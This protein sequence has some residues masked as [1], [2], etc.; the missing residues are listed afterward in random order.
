MSPLSIFGEAALARRN[1]QVLLQGP[2]IVCLT[3]AYVTDNQRVD[4]QKRATHSSPRAGWSPA[5]EVAEIATELFC[6]GIELQK[7]VLVDIGI[8]NS[9]PFGGGSGDRVGFVRRIGPRIE[10][11]GSG[12]YRKVADSQLVREIVRVAR[13]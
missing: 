2:K 6:V 10:N 9:V 11:F 12:L 1:D 4:G 13:R 5:L 3:L 8:L 7:A